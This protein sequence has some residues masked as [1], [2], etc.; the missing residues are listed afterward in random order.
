MKKIFTIAAREYRAM[1]GTKAFILSIV[2]MP[3]LFLGSLL[4]MEIM[5]KVSSVKELKIAV[6]DDTGEFYD[7]LEVALKL[8]NEISVSIT[9]GSEDSETEQEKPERGVPGMGREVYELEHIEGPMTDDLR[10]ELSKR[11]KDQD[12]YAFL[13]IPKQALKQNVK[14][15]PSGFEVDERELIRF[16]A[17]DSSLSQARR[18]LGA[19]IN[20]R[21][22]EIRLRAAKINPLLVKEASA[23]VPIVGKGLVERDADGNI[24]SEAETDAL[25]AIFLPMG[26]MMM[27]FMVI[28]MSAQPMLE[29]VLEEKSQR[30]A[31]VLLGSANHFN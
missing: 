28:F 23:E 6:I 30:I 9:D 3:I 18:T 10:V 21:A 8:S 27:M 2:M 16:Y 12:L 7:E 22:R 20:T 24:V 15:K 25:T 1:V 17:Q 13:E 29:S 19:L 4:A 31:E 26:V 14:I 5:E 11:I